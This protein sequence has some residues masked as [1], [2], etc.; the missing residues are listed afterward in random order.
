MKNDDKKRV[1]EIDKIFKGREVLLP[2]EFYE[3]Y[4]NDKSIPKY[5]VLESLKLLADELDADLSRLVPEDDFS[6][7]LRYLFEFDSMADVAIIEA[8]ESIFS[9]KISDNEAEN[10]KT[11]NDLVLFVSNRV[12][13]T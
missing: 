13:C 8:M 4:Y 12:N 10:I 7:N 3:K 5:I 11:I 6:K 2:D 1:A 9:I